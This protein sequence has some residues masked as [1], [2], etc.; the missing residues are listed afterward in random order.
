MFSQKKHHFSQKSLLTI[1]NFDDLRYNITETNTQFQM[2]S[3][4]MKIVAEL[5]DLLIKKP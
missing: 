4:F 5:P 1:V 3:Y 2:S